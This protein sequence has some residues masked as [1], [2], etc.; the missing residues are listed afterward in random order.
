MPGSGTSGTVARGSQVV[1]LHP[2]LLKTLRDQYEASQSGGITFD[3]YLGQ[4]LEAAA[5]GFRLPNYEPVVEAPRSGRRVTTQGPSH[6]GARKKNFPQKALERVRELER[7]P[8]K[9]AAILARG[10]W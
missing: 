5:A 8:D 4:L 6:N 3:N 1:N 10:E 7:D 2:D 9:I